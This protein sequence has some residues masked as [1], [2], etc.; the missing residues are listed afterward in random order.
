MKSEVFLQHD[1]YHNVITS[2]GV[3]FVCFTIPWLY[4]F[5]ARIMN[6]YTL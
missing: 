1:L 2:E 4:V 5:Y 3:H 6:I